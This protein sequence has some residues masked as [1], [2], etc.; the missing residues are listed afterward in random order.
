MRIDS[1]I[2]QFTPDAN[3]NI[4][5]E[6]DKLNGNIFDI[7][8]TTDGQNIAIVSSDNFYQSSDGVNGR[9][10]DP[11]GN[12]GERSLRL[13]CPPGIARTDVFFVT[14]LNP[15]TNARIYAVFSYTIDQ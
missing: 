7:E 6:I 14:I 8:L 15:T 12:A 9:V 11:T 13:T 10:I 5:I 1:T 2:Q 3:G 4:K